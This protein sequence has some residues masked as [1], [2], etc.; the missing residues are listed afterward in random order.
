MLLKLL[1]VCHYAMNIFLVVSGVMQMSVIEK[2]Q[3]K[4]FVI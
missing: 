2:W 3:H 4:T 1:S